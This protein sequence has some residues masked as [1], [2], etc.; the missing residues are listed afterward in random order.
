MQQGEQCGI[1]GLHAAGKRAEGHEDRSVLGLLI[2]KSRKR[3]F[4]L[5]ADEGIALPCKERLQR[6]GSRCA[7]QLAQRLRRHGSHR[8]ILVLKRP[9]ERI[10]PALLA[11][12]AQEKRSLDAHL[13]ARIGQECLGQIFDPAGP[14][15]PRHEQHT[16][17]R[18]E[19][20]HGQS[21]TRAHGTHPGVCC[22]GDGPL[23]GSSMTKADP[24]RGMS[25]TQM[26]PPCTST[27][28][29]AR[30]SPRP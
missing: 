17:H 22:L 12:F 3:D 29:F 11:Q 16:E 13:E 27:I 14:A 24:P 1:G 20:R 23:D 8:P 18:G 21:R 7:A 10:R 6:R 4:D 19:H 2:F 5:G 9:Y 15:H 25:C 28:S 26:V 30:A